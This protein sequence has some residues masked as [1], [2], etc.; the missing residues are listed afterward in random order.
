MSTTSASL[1]NLRAEKTRA[2]P[3]EMAGRVLLWLAIILDSALDAVP[4]LLGGGE[5]NSDQPGQLR[6]QISAVAEL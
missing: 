5:L 3:G 6:N 4:A 1:T 2:T